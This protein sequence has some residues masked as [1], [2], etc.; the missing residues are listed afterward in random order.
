MPCSAQCNKNTFK[1][2]VS[3][4]KPDYPNKSTNLVVLSFK[5]GTI[6]IL[7]KKRFKSYAT[8]LPQ[9]NSLEEQES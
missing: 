9:F 4:Q 1:S 8:L 5:V 6:L 7:E 3:F 2:S